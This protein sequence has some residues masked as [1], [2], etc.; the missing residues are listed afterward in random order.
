[1]GNGNMIEL[2]QANLKA[3]LDYDPN[4]G[5]LTWKPR[6]LPRKRGSATWN[7]RYAGKEALTVKNH[8]GYLTG[9]VFGRHVLAHRIIWIMQTGQSPIQIDHIN[10]KPD[11]NRWG[12]LRAVSTSQN[13]RN[14]RQRRDLPLGIY[15]RRDGAAGFVATIGYRLHGKKVNEHLG[16][17]AT[18]D[19]A[20]SA[21][22][23]AE[24]RLGFHPNHGRK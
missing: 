15:P 12:N 1:M 13:C 10:G 21:R 7:T 23:K 6:D 20:I 3:V 9:T 4:T 5:R 14:K 17:F 11:D 16:S 24:R 19:E 8:K 22:Q 18:L 2:N